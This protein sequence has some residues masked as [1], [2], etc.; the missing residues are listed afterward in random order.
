VPDLARELLLRGI[1]IGLAASLVLLVTF[2]GIT[3]AFALFR[4][5]AT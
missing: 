1:A 5:V 4:K 2:L 3:L